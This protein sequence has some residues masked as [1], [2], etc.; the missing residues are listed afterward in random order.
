MWYGM[1]GMVWYGRYGMVFWLQ[2]RPQRKSPCNHNSNHEFARR[3]VLFWRALEFSALFGSQNC[4][5]RYGL[6]VHHIYNSLAGGRQRVN[7][8]Q[9]EAEG[10]HQAWVEEDKTV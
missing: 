2:R 4:W 5:T 9:A 10:D 6:S 3:S 7:A 1:V 8:Q